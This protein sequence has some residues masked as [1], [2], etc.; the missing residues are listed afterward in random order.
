MGGWEDGS[1]SS[2]LHGGNACKVNFFAGLFIA[3]FFLSPLLLL[4]FFGRGEG[5]GK[6][7]RQETFIREIIS[8]SI[9]YREYTGREHF[10]TKGLLKKENSS[11]K[12][13]A[14]KGR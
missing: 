6:N 14:W 10:S 2:F 11:R 8:V 1:R 7:A 4:L 12:P 9:G 13:L 3:R 5:E